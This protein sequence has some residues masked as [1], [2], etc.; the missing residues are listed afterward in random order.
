M[1]TG[2]GADLAFRHAAGSLALKLRCGHEI[3]T[4]WRI[5]EK[6]EARFYHENDLSAEGSAAKE[7][8]RFQK[9]NAHEERQER[10]EE[11]TGE[12]KKETHGITQVRN[13]EVLENKVVFKH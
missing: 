13:K 7:G 11:K 2:C 10:F 1:Q 12:G 4:L 3:D 9:E 5:V 6:K 8:A